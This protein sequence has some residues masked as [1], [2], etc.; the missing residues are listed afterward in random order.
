[1]SRV[2]V[3]KNSL[4]LVTGFCALIL[5]LVPANAQTVTGSLYGT[6]TDSTGA[7][8]PRAQVTAT[9]TGTNQVLR[10]ESGAAGEYIFPV[11]NPGRYKVTIV[12]QGFETTTATDAQVDANRNVNVSFSLK[13]GAAT[14]EVSVSADTT[15]IDTRESQ[16]GET[17]D[18]K[19]MVDLPLIGRNAYDLVQLV[20]GVTNYNAAPPIGDNGGTQF[21]VNGLRPNF[22][23]FYL[24]GAYNT[25][26]FRGGGNRAPAPDALSQF[27]IL[28]SN[29]DAE[30][31]RYPGAVVNTI[32]RSGT[33]QIHGV[34]YDYNRNAVFNAKGYF[35]GNGNVQKQVYNIFGAG[36]GGAIIK[37][38]LFAFLSYQGTRLREATNIGSGGLI[39]PSDLERTGDFSQPGTSNK[40]SLAV[41]PALKCKTDAVT[42]AILQYVPRAD[43]G[44]T[45]TTSAGLLV[46]HPLGQSKANPTN[47]DQGTARLDYQLTASQKLQF[48]YFRSQGTGIDYTAGAN[49]LLNYSG[50]RTSAGQSNYVIGHTWIIS[51]KV[52]NTLTGF[53][54]LNK[55]VRTNVYST[56]MLSDLGSAIKNGGPITTQPQVRVTG[57]FSGGVGGS[58]PT[59]SAQLQAGLEDTANLSFHKNLLKFGGAVIFNRYAETAA[60]QSSTISTFNGNAA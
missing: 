37:D 33:N 50:N 13:P 35:F 51:P 19:R 15:L 16:L 3:L 21:S 2:S 47:A 11:V 25:S 45:T 1:M 41:C 34:I 42:Q 14:T 31:G 22:N 30:F 58:G 59:T 26:F 48:T 38:K 12:M 8:I 9:N 57:F 17:I 29:F 49:N 43:P 4:R 5:M 60:F 18:Q 54:T 56:A 20:P 44:S 32:T 55:Y 23:S 46:F 40:P 28:T 52:V 10:V 53:Y 6:I 39:V 27:R 24:D 7:A 36:V